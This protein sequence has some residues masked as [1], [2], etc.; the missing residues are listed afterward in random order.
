MLYTIDDIK[1]DFQSLEVLELK[2]VEV[3]LAEGD[4]HKG[5]SSVIRF[6]GK[7]VHSSKF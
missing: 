6:V 4:H 7:K 3:Y 5:L 2:E 1:S